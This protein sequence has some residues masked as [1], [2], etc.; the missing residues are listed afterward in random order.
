MGTGSGRDVLIRGSVPGPLPFWRFCRRDEEEKGEVVAGVVV[1]GGALGRSADGRGNF[2]VWL[3][4]MSL[5]AGR[6]AERFI[7]AVVWLL[8]VLR[9]SCG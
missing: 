4:R 6:K 9:W 7:V 8:L 5:A 3:G 1:R 2:E